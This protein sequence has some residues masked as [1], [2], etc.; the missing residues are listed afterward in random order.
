MEPYPPEVEEM[1]HR[2]VNDNYNYP[3]TTIRNGL[4]A[5]IDSVR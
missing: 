4:I 1:M 3:V 2:L 5:D